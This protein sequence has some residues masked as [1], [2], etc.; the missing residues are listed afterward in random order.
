MIP[1]AD[2]IRNAKD[3]GEASAIRNKVAEQADKGERPMADWDEANRIFFSTW[4][5]SLRRP[6]LNITPPISGYW[7]D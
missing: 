2:A 3:H 7:G 1:E 4:R 5:E 6:E